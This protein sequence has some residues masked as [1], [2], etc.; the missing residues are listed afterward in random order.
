MCICVYACTYSKLGL[1]GYTDS[2]RIVGKHATIFNIIPLLSILDPEYETTVDL[3]DGASQAGH[4]S[5][6]NW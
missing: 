6:N 1:P 5:N 2:M 3:N 4:F